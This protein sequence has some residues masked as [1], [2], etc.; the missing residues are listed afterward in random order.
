MPQ[1]IS[2]VLPLL[3]SDTKYLLRQNILFSY[4]RYPF[5]FAHNFLLYACLLFVVEPTFRSTSLWQDGS[6]PD[7]RKLA[8]SYDQLTYM[9][10][11]FSTAWEGKTGCLAYLYLWNLNQVY[12]F[13]WRGSIDLRIRT[14]CCQACFYL[15]YSIII[16]TNNH[17]MY[18]ETS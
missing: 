4:P 14:H 16:I 3:S 1:L 18:R 2:P 13:T 6:H 7:V 9:Q 17:I 11:I 15:Q 12:V 10:V 5:I 8:L